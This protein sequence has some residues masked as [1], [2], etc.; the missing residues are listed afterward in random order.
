MKNSIVIKNLNK[1]Y[2]NF[3]LKNINLTIPSGCIVGLIGENGAGK[4]T[5]IKSLLNIININ[6]GTIELFNKNSKEN[7]VLLKREIGVVL[8]DSFFQKY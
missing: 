1:K 4:T 5:L 3:E 7:E 2:P 6:N 8:D